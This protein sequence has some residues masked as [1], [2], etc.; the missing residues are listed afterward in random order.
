MAHRCWPDPEARFK[1]FGKDSG[2]NFFLEAFQAAPQ[3]RLRSTEDRC[4]SQLADLTVLNERLA[5]RQTTWQIRTRLEYLKTRRRNWES[6]YEYVTKADASATLAMIEEANRKVEAA[7]SE[8]SRERTSVVALKTQ[9]VELQQEVNAAHQRLHLTQARVDFNMQRINELKEEATQLERMR[10]MLSTAE[11]TLDMEPGLRNFWYPTAFSSKVDA[12]MLVPFDLFGEPWV[13]FRNETGVVSC[14]KDECA[15]RACPLSLGKVV[16]GKVQ[17]P[18]HGWEYTGAGECVTMP[19]TVQCLGIRVSS[20][21]CTE[22]DGFVWVWPGSQPPT[23]LPALAQPPK[24]FTMHAEIE[25]EVPVEHGLLLENLLDLA[26]APFTHTSTFAKG[27]PIPDFVKFKAARLLGGNW[28]PY[29]IDMSFEP[30]C[31]VVSLIGLSQPGKIKR[32]LRAG[33]CENHL[34]QLHVCLPSKK[35]HTRLLYRM[36]MDFMDWTRS[37]PGIQRFWRYIAGQVLGEDLVLVAGQQDRMERGS[38]TWANPVSYDKLA[39]RYRRWR[40]SVDGDSNEQQAAV[41]ALTRMS[42]GELFSMSEDVA[43]LEEGLACDSNG[44]SV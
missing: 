3:V 8:E 40:N 35:G 33:E 43:D 4:R 34:H 21:P 5:G 28:D 41:A 7:L 44:C 30:P 20:L 13:L 27:W 37:V 24:G 10:S 36:S 9:L 29:P 16:D 26:H 32:G 42:A 39:V 2:G 12:N 11:S 23:E 6:I 15:H 31:C 18:Y 38:D 22:Q 1:R 17:C 14:V 19:S 25:V